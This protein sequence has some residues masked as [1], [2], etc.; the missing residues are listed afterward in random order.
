MA[1]ALHGSEKKEVLEFISKI[2]G[3]LKLNETNR[4]DG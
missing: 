1:S 3:S 2:E 4:L